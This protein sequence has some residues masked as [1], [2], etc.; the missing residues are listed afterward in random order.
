MTTTSRHLERIRRLCTLSLERL[1]LM[2]EP[3]SGLVVFR[4]DGDD[5][6]PAGTTARY[7]A[8]TSLGLERAIQHGWSSK[9]DPGQLL[10]A[11]DRELPGIENSGD[12]GLVAWAAARLAKPLAERAVGRLLDFGPLT[13]RRSGESVHSTELA[14]VVTGLAEALAHDVGPSGPV[15]ARFDEAFAMLLAQRGASGL[16]TFS[17]PLS[18]GASI[19]EHFRSEF[20]F[21]DAQVYTIIA[22][23][24]RFELLGDAD[25]RDMAKVI[26][27]GILAHQH[28]LGQWAWHYN[29]RTGALVDLYP[30]YSVHQDGMAPMALLP[31]ESILGVPTEAAVARGVAWL[32][33]DNELGL[34]LADFE[35]NTIWRSIRRRTPYRN[36]VYPLKF[37]SLARVGDGLDLGARL[38]QPSRLEIDREFRPY[39]LG[40]CLYAFAE[41]AAL[42]P[43]R[44]ASR[45]AAAASNAA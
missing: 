45:K 17:R 30:V 11:L 43:D 6:V 9:L 42:G 15:R 35:R 13:Q 8:M 41:L 29:V 23:L 26:G 38:A 33:G 44:A 12:I 31:L 1:P 14:W 40:F 28:P 36:V 19:R 21:F 4:V 39:H 37:A 5:L 20:G 3:H 22:A 24:R 18:P 2:V 16:M 7:T 27:Q 34:P 10:A 25:A 32:F